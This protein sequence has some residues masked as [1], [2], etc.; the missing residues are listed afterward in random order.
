MIEANKKQD[1]LEPV[2]GTVEAPH[3]E[4][5]SLE[6]RS[7]RRPVE[8]DI[9]ERTRQ[10]NTNLRFALAAPVLVVRPPVA[11]FRRL[12]V[13]Q[14]PTRDGEP[15]KEYKTYLGRYQLHR[16]SENVCSCGFPIFDLSRGKSKIEPITVMSDD[17]HKARPSVA[18]P[19]P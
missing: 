12:A 1:I 4:G 7:G 14:K 9:F 2:D 5:G 8:C 11:T 15:E 3:G 16:Q 13:Q 10:N 18:L 19:W 17:E 6:M